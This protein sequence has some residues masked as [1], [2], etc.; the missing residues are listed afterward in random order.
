MTE[1]R[2]K[3]KSNE[4]ED[5]KKKIAER[6][7]AGKEPTEKEQEKDIDKGGASYCKSVEHKDE[8]CTAP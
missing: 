4:R 1:K 8:G 5:E 3:E 2:R 7:P 6:D